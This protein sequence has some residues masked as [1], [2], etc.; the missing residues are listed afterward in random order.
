MESVYNL[1]FPAY[2][3]EITIH[4]YRFSR[5]PE[6]RECVL[7]LQHLIYHTHEFSIEPN[8]GVHA[9]TAY[10]ERP[11][12]EERSVLPWAGEGPT[13][14]LEDVLLLLSIFTSR[15]VFIEGRDMPGTG[16]TFY[17]DPRI[18]PGGHILRASIPYKRSPE[19][20]DEFGL[21][22]DTGFE[23]SLN[24]GNYSGW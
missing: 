10:L 22:H 6:Y 3:S 15:D 24:Q 23:E 17:H 12:S 9:I 16:G 1:E 14:A 19:V 20:P 13:T 18:H 7:R 4:G 11:G 21:Y 2:C 8:S 5:V